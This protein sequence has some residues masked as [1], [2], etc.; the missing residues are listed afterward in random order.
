M[1]P[2]L[3]RV[4]ITGVEKVNVKLLDGGVVEGPNVEKVR[5]PVVTMFAVKE[6][7]EEIETKFPGPVSVTVT[8]PPGKLPVKV[9][10]P[11]AEF[12]TT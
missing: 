2:I 3:Y 12:Q 11:P 6:E 5:E 9:L 10:A 8:V 7:G 4:I 1:S